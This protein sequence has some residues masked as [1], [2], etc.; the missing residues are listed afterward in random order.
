[1]CLVLCAMLEDSHAISLS[2]TIMSEL[3]P[4]VDGEAAEGGHRCRCVLVCL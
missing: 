2:S 3:W 1:M 4:C